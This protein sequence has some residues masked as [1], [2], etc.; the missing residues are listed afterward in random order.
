M[1]TSLDMP[2][3]RLALIGAHFSAEYEIFH[4]PVRSLTQLAIGMPEYFTPMVISILSKQ[5]YASEYP[6]LNLN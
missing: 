6:F 4:S 2:H 3:L 1:S 5:L